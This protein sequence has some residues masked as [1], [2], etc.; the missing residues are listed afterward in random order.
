MFTL[1]LGPDDFSKKEHI[2][3][4]AAKESL[5]IERFNAN[6]EAPEAAKLVEQNLFSKQKIFILEGLIGKFDFDTAAPEFIASQNNIF[7][8]EEKLDKR[9]TATKELLKNKAVIVKEFLLPH[10]KDFE[11]WIAEELHRQGAAA[12]AKAIALLAQK[13]GRDETVETKFG[14]KVVDRKE[15]YTL[16]QAHNEIK[17]LL[18][19]GEGTFDEVLIEESVSQQSEPDVLAIVNA[20]AEGKKQEAMTQ[21][22]EFISAGAAAGEKE[23]IIHISALLSEQF[24]NVAMIQSFQKSG[25]R[26][27]DILDSTGWKSG[28]LFV[29]SKI[30][31]RFDQK[32]VLE[33]LEK[34]S[35]LD[36]ELKTGNTPPR[37]LL[38]LILV[39]LL[40]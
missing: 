5:E 19:L 8:I 22:Q 2:T 36:E 10:G 18:A 15:I 40:A 38:D 30:A 27:Q 9:L 25:A 37:V 4:L 26:E 23:S 17:K 11:N 3:V 16:W 34:L 32:K 39:Q 20:I 6:G 12:S 7:F 14:G 35:L 28:R 24:R 31:N 33:A 1:L 21:L 29:I 13:L